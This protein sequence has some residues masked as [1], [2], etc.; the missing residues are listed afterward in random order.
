MSDFCRG[1]EISPY[2]YSE[3]SKY[4]LFTYEDNITHQGDQHSVLEAVALNFQRIPWS[5]E[6]FLKAL[7]SQQSE[8]FGE[9]MSTERG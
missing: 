8:P 9:E 1:L 7:C 6:S 3:R 2:F 4:R 5:R